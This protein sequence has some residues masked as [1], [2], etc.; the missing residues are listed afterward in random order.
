MVKKEIKF[1]SENNKDLDS[2][3][4]IA[5]IIQVASNFNS[6]IRLEVDGR[7]ANAKSLLGVMSLALDPDA[8]V[9]VSAEGP[10]EDE[11]LETVAQYLLKPELD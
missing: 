4:A 8:L 6:D 2:G 3:R 11:A 1:L 9:K 7:R 10:D 5:G